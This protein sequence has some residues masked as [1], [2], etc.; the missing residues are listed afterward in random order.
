M[1]PNALDKVVDDVEPPVKQQQLPTATEAPAVTAR[2][3]VPVIRSWLYL[4]SSELECASNTRG[5]QGWGP[6]DQLECDMSISYPRFLSKRS[7]RIN[8]RSA[9]TTGTLLRVTLNT[10]EPAAH[11]PIPSPKELL[12]RCAERLRR[13]S[14]GTP[15][16]KAAASVS[17]GHPVVLDDGSGG[18]KGL[19]FES[20]VATQLASNRPEDL[21]SVVLLLIAPMRRL[22]V[23]APKKSSEFVGSTSFSSFSGNAF[24]RVMFKGRDL[25]KTEADVSNT[26][27]VLLALQLAHIRFSLT[28]TPPL[29]LQLGGIFKLR[30]DVWLSPLA[31]QQHL[32]VELLIGEA[33][34]VLRNAIMGLFSRVLKWKPTKASVLWSLTG[35]GS[36]QEE[37]VEEDVAGGKE[38]ETESN[39]DTEAEP[40]EGEDEQLDQDELQRKNNE[41][42]G[43]GT[44]DEIDYQ[45]PHSPDPLIFATTLRRY[46]S[47]AFN[48]MQK[49]E[50][51]L[52]ADVGTPRNEEVIHPM[53]DEFTIPLTSR[54]LFVNHMSGELQLDAPGPK[55]DCFGGILADEMGLGKTVE[56]LSVISRDFDGHTLH[57]AWR[58]G[59]TTTANKEWFGGTLIV[60]PL[61]LIAQW[62]SE[63]E[64]HFNTA[65]K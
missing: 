21:M 12:S 54:A 45:T 25:G 23:A 58:H 26:I 44:L 38:A 24:V 62:A 16:K 46:Q 11:A 42:F 33:Q 64:R 22:G 39:A 28:E 53:W 57:R 8:G 36:G 32:F 48:W 4:G 1:L 63:I 18:L 60:M 41:V 59:R 27:A 6:G 49:R 52:W 5:P 30:V 65:G 17:S 51:D 50:E 35:G 3:E 10:S 20:Y 56:M 13:H 55:S 7:L 61:S 43:T 29:E 14:V 19:T 31:L 2:A 40:A 37:I 47:I 9:I 34:A 15:T